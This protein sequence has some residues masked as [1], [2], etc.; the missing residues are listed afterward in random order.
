MSLLTLK[1]LN[2]GQRTPPI[3]VTALKRFNGGQTKEGLD[4]QLCSHESS[5]ESLSHISTVIGLDGYQL[6]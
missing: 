6:P 5:I 1:M 3:T 4:R 2:G